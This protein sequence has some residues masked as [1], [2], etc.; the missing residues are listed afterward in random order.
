MNESEKAFIQS[1]GER[2]YQLRTER[3]WTQMDLGARCG[4]DAT[5]IRRVEKGQTNPT[6]L[7]LFRIAQAFEIEVRELL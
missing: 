7:T 3:G 2:I 5:Q 6:A 1:I 4:M